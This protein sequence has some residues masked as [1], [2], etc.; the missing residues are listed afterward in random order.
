MTKQEI[1]SR[2]EQTIT[3]HGFTFEYHSDRWTPVVRQNDS[4][5]TGITISTELGWDA[6]NREIIEK[7]HC[8]AYVAK[9]GGN[10]T[11]AEFMA[12]AEEIARAAGLMDEINAMGLNS[13]EKID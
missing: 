13:R 6:D 4:S 7:V 1:N 3:A 12:A 11:S 2:L 10:P 8:E 5:Y 9:M